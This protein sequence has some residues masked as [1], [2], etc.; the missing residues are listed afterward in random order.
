MAKEYC[1]A[2]MPITSGPSP[3]TGRRLEYD[4]DAMA[5]CLAC[6]AD[7]FDLID[8]GE[9]HSAGRDEELDA[10]GRVSLAVGATTESVLLLLRETTVRAVF[11]DE[12]VERRL[13]SFARVSSGVL[14]R[15]LRGG[16]QK[17]A[18]RGSM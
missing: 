11:L 1:V 8:A 15:R 2:K 7:T 17:Q 14:P 4:D 13:F 18:T 12:C 9:V 10:S 16:L 6:G 3:P 5:T